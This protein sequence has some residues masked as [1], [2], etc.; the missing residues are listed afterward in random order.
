[1]A[2]PARTWIA[3][4]DSSTLT[5]IDDNIALNYLADETGTVR[6]AVDRA[7]LPQADT[8]AILAEAGYAAHEIEDLRSAGVI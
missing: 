6:A 8:D 4:R 1:M 7:R 3:G 2:E 5:C